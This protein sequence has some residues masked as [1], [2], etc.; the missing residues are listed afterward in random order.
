MTL[1]EYGMKHYAIVIFAGVVITTFVLY[2]L[3]PPSVSTERLISETHSDVDS[4][5]IEPT[6]QN[7]SQL[8]PEVAEKPLGRCVVDGFEIV[9]FSPIPVLAKLRIENQT[10]NVDLELQSDK[11]VDSAVTKQLNTLDLSVSYE[12]V[13]YV[14]ETL[15]RQAESILDSTEPEALELFINDNPTAIYSV[16]LDPNIQADYNRRVLNRYA[17]N[18]IDLLRYA[19]LVNRSTADIEYLMTFVPDLNQ[20]W[21]GYL[22]KE[23]IASAALWAARPEILRLML[24]KGVQLQNQ[25]QNLTDPALILD[26]KRDSFDPDIMTEFASIAQDYNYTD[27]NGLMARL[28]HQEPTGSSRTHMDQNEQDTKHALLTDYPYFVLHQTSNCK[29]GTYRPYLTITEF[30]ARIRTLKDESFTNE[31]IESVLAKESKLYVEI[32]RTRSVSDK[33]SD[34]PSQM[35]MAYLELVSEAL[36]TN[37][38]NAV[39][40][41]LSNESSPSDRKNLM[42]LLIQMKAPIEV[43]QAQLEAVVDEGNILYFS[44]I[45]SDNVAAADTLKHA[46]Q[47]RPIIDKYG[48]NALYYSIT[49]GASSSLAHAVR[50]DDATFVDERGLNPAEMLLLAGFEFDPA[51]MQYVMET[52][53]I[54]EQY[55]YLKAVNY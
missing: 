14:P 38:W 22:G 9:G 52:Y 20:T 19:I 48:R 11:Q 44:A 3:S 21:N 28:T 43:Y 40:G 35:Q 8:N 15:L 18:D 4:N 17:Y 1:K 13:N 54:S 6:L 50:E 37:D 31:Q 53:P 45:L 49:L 10:Y 16:L 25:E 33:Q 2:Q 12:P 51:M 34:Q 41:L 29:K 24:Q 46:Q 55:A 32:F 36:S 30:D 27:E 42:T 7:K 5:V 26:N 47:N 39:L 23:N